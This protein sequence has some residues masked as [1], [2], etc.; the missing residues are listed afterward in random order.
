MSELKII[1]L[2][3]GFEVDKEKSTDTEIVLKESN[4]PFNPKTWEEIQKFN[5]DNNK[6]QYF[7]NALGNTIETNENLVRF[8][9]SNLPSKHIAEKI[10]ALCQLYVIAEYYNG[11]WEPMYDDKSTSVKHSPYWDGSTNK[12]GI[13]S[14][15][16]ASDCMP[17]FKNYESIKEAYNHN[18]EIF[19][20]ALKP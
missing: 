19:E 12:L 10:R 11:D 9:R 4:K 16:T 7:V 20:T 3:E 6:C 15:R 14:F 13:I 5:A 2:P 8:G 18:K 1:K 17:V